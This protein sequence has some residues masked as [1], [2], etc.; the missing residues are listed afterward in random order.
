MAGPLS[1]KCTCGLPG[2]NLLVTCVPISR[3]TVNDIVHSPIEIALIITTILSIY[4]HWPE[5]R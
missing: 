1:A 4:Q 3:E 5:T 2:I